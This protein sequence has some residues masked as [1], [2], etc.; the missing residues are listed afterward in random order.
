MRLV[1]CVEEERI[2]TSLVITSVLDYT[3]HYTL[4]ITSVIDYTTLGITSVIDYTTHYTT[5]E[6]HH[7]HYT[8]PITPGITQTWVV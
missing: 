3:T 8:T 1:C 4:G 2:T 7:F 6:L 5:L